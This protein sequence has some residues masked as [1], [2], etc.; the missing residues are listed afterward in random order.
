MNTTDFLQLQAHVPDI[1]IILETKLRLLAYSE[2]H[3]LFYHEW[4]P[5]S[6]EMD[7][8]IYKSETFILFE[9]LDEYRPTYMIVNDRKRKLK[10][11]PELKEF[12]VENTKTLQAL[13][14]V[15]NVAIINNELL[16][17]QG[18]A[19]ST[20]DEVKDK[21][22]PNGSQLRYFIDVNLAVRWLGI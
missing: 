12:L 22:M 19:E 9:V 8:E 14:S 5:D 7:E 2:K 13:A 21:S 18:Q 3:S 16:S 6:D 4:H 20:M 10:I 15:K 17:N 11:S 1:K